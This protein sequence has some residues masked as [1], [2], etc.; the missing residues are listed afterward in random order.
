MIQQCSSI[1][2]LKIAN[3]IDTTTSKKKKRS[4]DGE[5]LPK[6]KKAKRTSDGVKTSTNDFSVPPNGQRVPVTQDPSGL[7]LIDSNPEN[8]DV[9]LKLA[10]DRQKSQ[11]KQKR[12]HEP[13]P[14]S[15]A[16][17][18]NG[19][20]EVEHLEPKEITPKR[21]KAKHGKVVP[22]PTDETSDD[23]HNRSFEQ[24]VALRLK[25]KDEARKSK[26]N[27]K[28]KRESDV[29]V[30]DNQADVDHEVKQ[31]TTK[32]SKGKAATTKQL[33][34]TKAPKGVKRKKRNSKDANTVNDT[35]QQKPKKKKAKRSG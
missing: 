24:K 21:K 8:V 3:G 12:E 31:T 2:F 4:E 32:K 19:S 14:E 5:S 20:I 33:A 7:F 6:S 35:S 29:S 9:L 17:E 26:A 23:Q 34:E 28:R 27:K 15:D 13:E 1:D 30:D 25:E 10:Q 18:V 22:E 16:E 11:K